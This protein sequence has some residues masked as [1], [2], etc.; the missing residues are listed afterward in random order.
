MNSEDNVL[1]KGIEAIF[2]KTAH[3]RQGQEKNLELPNGTI[4]REGDELVIRLQLDRNDD[5][6]GAV[7]ELAEAA[8]GGMLDQLVDLTKVKNR[9]VEHLE[10][11]KIAVEDG[12][13]ASAVEELLSALKIVDNAD[14]RF[15]LAILYEDMKKADLAMKEYKAVLAMNPKHV[16]ALN[17]LGLLYY[18]KDNITKAMD[19][20]QK[21]VRLEPGLTSKGSG[22]DFFA[23]R[24]GPKDIKLN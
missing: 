10:M 17:N 22:S 12:D 23:P 18:K 13:L 14:I 6:R 19:Y 7:E 8:R 11:A 1:G 21:A 3:L 15:N 9:L 5:V 24:F 4:K 20:Y 16:M 2:K